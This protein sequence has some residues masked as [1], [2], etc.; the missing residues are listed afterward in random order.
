[1]K[2]SLSLSV[3]SQVKVLHPGEEFKVLPGVVH[4]PFNAS[5]EEVIVRGPLTEEDAIPRDFVLFLSQIYG[6]VDESPSHK[7]LPAMLLQMSIFTPRYDS[8]LVSPP[9]AVQRVQFAILHPI[10]RLLGYRCYYE[11]FA[12]GVTAHPA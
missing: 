7:T 10:A 8:W 1:V 9:L 5:D 12:P 3:G 4:Q 2:G 6:Y 11:R